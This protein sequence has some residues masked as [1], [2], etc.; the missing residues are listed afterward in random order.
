MAVVL[1]ERK[2]VI[3]DNPKLGLNGEKVSCGTDLAELVEKMGCGRVDGYSL[4][5]S[6]RLSKEQ[7]L[8]VIERVKEILQAIK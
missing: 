7:M 2:W 3:R 6:Y 5:L 8:D 4:S 1:N